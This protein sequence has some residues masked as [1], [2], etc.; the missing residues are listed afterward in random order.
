M[1]GTAGTHSLLQEVQAG[2]F[3]VSRDMLSIGSKFGRRRAVFLDRDGTIAHYRE[4]CRQ[5]RDFRLLPGVGEAICRLN[6]AGLLVIV[7]TNQSAIGRGWLTRQTLEEIHH[8]M[9][10]QLRRSGARLDAIYVCPHHPDNG[11]SCRKPNAAMFQHAAA[12]FR[13]SLR[14]CYAVGDRL[15]DVLAGRTVGARTVLVRSGHTLEAASGVKP[16]HEAANLVEASMWVLKQE[17][18]RAQ[19][20]SRR[21]TTES[22]M[23]S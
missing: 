7:V 22:A 3:L 10:R 12:T 16:D 21:A 18:V 11:C 1:I 19:T 14:R 20:I 17:I 23:A 5:P 4:Y 8:K 15:L 9:R 13:L 6:E 2:G